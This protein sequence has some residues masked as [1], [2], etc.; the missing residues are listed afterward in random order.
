MARRLGLRTVA[1]GV[2]GEDPVGTMCAPHWRRRG[3]TWPG[4][5]SP[6]VT[7]GAGPQLVGGPTGDL[8][9]AIIRAS[10]GSL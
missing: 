5:S 1:V 10:R 3:W 9:M 7:S 4:C 8:R 6:E 2:M